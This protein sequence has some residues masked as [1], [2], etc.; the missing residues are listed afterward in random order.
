MIR[1]LTAYMK[2]KVGLTMCYHQG[3]PFLLK[4]NRLMKSYIVEPAKIQYV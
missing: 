3:C 1:P 4:L 2:V